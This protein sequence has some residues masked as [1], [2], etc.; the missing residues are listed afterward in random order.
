[1]GIFD[2]IS[3]MMY[4]KI[5]LLFFLGVFYAVAQEDEPRVI[6]YETTSDADNSP[7]KWKGTDRNFIRF[8]ATEVL[9]GE[10]MLYYE[11]KLNDLM[12]FE[13]GLGVTKR[14][15]PSISPYTVLY[16][17]P[18]T[19]NP[20]QNHVVDPLIG[21]SFYAG[22]RFYP[23]FGF[24]ENDDTKLYYFVDLRYR[25]YNWMST[26]QLDYDWSTLSYETLTTQENHRILIPRLGAGSTLYKTRHFVVDVFTS[27]GAMIIN[28]DAY[29]PKVAEQSI[30]NKVIFWPGTGIH[31][32]I[33]L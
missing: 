31:I 9:V 17:E 10:F 32:G 33:M 30:S 25:G 11:R 2:K 19:M 16:F 6:V 14:R 23:D 24:I 5:S 21:Q 20:S 13:V 26:Y 8:G 29:D 4:L 7:I 27:F 28:T 22:F 18:S 3:A 12:A 15:N 1:M